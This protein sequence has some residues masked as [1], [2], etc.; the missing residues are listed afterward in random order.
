MLL[1]VQSKVLAFLALRPLVSPLATHLDRWRKWAAL[2]TFTVASAEAMCKAQSY[3]TQAAR[4]R[5]LPSA[6]EQR[7]FAV[8]TLLP[9]RQEMANAAANMTRL[10]L[11]AT[12]GPGE[13]GMLSTVHDTVCT[14]TTPQ[15]HPRAL[16][17]VLRSRPHAHPLTRSPTHP[18]TR[19]HAH[20]LTRSAVHLLTTHPL[21]R[22]PAHPLTLFPHPLT[23]SP[24]RPLAPPRFSTRTAR[25]Q[26]RPSST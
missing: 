10:L 21:T 16:T 24:S 25:T 19:S 7:R 12:D 5:A 26:T 17:L 14:R 15:A 22:S 18:L 4:A 9:L 2:F 20:T 23:R 11:E 8:S 6:A 1:E 3:V 13:M